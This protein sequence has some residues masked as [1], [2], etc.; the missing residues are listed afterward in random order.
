MLS[1]QEIKELVEAHTRYTIRCECG[2]FLLK[3]ENGF[4]SERE[5]WELHFAAV[6]FEVLNAG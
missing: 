6:L 2:E 1:Q 5:Q 3:Q 4:M